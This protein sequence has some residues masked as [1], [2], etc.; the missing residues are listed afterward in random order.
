VTTPVGTP[1]GPCDVWPAFWSC[2][3]SCESTEVTGRA[4]RFATEVL[5]ALSGRQFGLCTVTLRPCRTEC[6]GDWGVGWWGDQP[7]WATGASYPMPA[8]I[9]GAW[10]NLICGV[11][12]SSC[13]CSQLSEVILPAP[14]Y[15]VVEVKVD[16]APLA[17]GAYRLDDDR[18]LVRV[19]GGEWPRCNDLRL[20]DTEVGTWS[21]TARFGQA[22]PEGAAWAVGELA[23]Q[24][25]TAINGGDCRLPKQVT[26]LVRQGVTIQM[27]SIT[28]LLKDGVT[29]LYFV[30]LFIKTWNPGRLRRRS[31]TYVVDGTRPRRVGT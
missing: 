1:F 14:V 4:A 24:L 16:G 23:C 29:G 9:G 30:D 25:V 10:F 6:F 17:T 3:V 12:G 20:A 21:V 11:C 19:D 26:Q 8:L 18:T 7:F 13:S 22:V 27:D 31:R 28:E 2:D 5:W 15:D